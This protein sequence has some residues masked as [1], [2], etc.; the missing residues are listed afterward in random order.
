M[1]VCAYA[2]ANACEC[3]CV[4]VRLYLTSQ[5]RTLRL[6]CAEPPQSPNYL[7]RC[8]HN[9]EKKNKKN[10]SKGQV[11]SNKKTLEE[12]EGEKKRQVPQITPP[13]DGKHPPDATAPNHPPNP[14]TA[15][16]PTTPPIPATRPRTPWSPRQPGTSRMMQTRCVW[17]D[18]VQTR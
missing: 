5:Q 11:S 7:L 4:K 14:R 17:G 3:V 1:I 15:N 10:G 12:K 6:V 9:N 13:V 8:V 18:S 2:S 16:T